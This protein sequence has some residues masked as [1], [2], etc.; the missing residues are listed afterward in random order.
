MGDYLV[1]LG[2]GVGGEVRYP[3]GGGVSGLYEGREMELEGI[4]KNGV[5]EWW[6]DG[7]K[8]VTSNQ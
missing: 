2:I 6:S 1:V 5:L 8:P 7:R 3:S 4:L